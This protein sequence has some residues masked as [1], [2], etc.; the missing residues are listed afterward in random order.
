MIESY[1]PLVSPMKATKATLT[2]PEITSAVFE[3]AN[4]MV[5]VSKQF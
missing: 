4:M 2:V 5:Q 3:P 1:A